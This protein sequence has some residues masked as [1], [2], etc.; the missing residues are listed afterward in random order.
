MGVF[1]GLTPV[2]GLNVSY[3]LTQPN[4][5]RVVIPCRDD[6]TGKFIL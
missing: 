1:Q 3:V 5:E 6:G 4:D 2:H